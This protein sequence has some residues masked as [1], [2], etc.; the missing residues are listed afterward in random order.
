[1]SA[2]TNIFKVLVTAIRD[3]S[4]GYLAGGANLHSVALAITAANRMAL[5]SLES[6]RW[7][8]NKSQ[9]KERGNHYG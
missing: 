7:D 4:V 3:A 9:T 2:G 5:A 8:S 6:W 1:M